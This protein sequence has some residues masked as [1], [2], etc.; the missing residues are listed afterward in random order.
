MLLPSSG[1]MISIT[2]L[3]GRTYYLYTDSVL[4]FVDITSKFSTIA[5]FGAVTYKQYSCFKSRYVY[6]LLQYQISNA[7]FQWFASY[8]R[9]TQKMATSLNYC[10]ILLQGSEI[11]YGTYTNDVHR[12]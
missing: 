4:H 5:I 12:N 7:L 8:C 6:D 1:S 3:L 11:L 10:G 9:H 2:L